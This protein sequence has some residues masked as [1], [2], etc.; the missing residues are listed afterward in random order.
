MIP[1]ASRGWIARLALVALLIAVAAAGLALGIRFRDRVNPPL[2]HDG[3][4]MP[5]APLAV[6]TA[7]PTVTLK[8]QR[9]RE[10][11]TDSLLAGRG[12]VVMFLEIGCP[13]CSVM[14]ARW[15]R[16][17]DEA[18]SQAPPVFGVSSSSLESIVGYGQRTGIRFQIFQ[19]PDQIFERVHK[20]ESF[21]FLVVVDRSLQVREH[22]FDSNHPIDLERFDRLLRQ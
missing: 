14:V 13:P 19:D 11:R 2:S 10:I 7:F 21:P 12:G 17:L 5:P 3:A 9:G 1:G 6:G 20:V 18:P 22:T 16:A 8:D 15:Q 4:V